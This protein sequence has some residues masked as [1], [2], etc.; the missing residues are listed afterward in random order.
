MVFSLTASY[1]GQ[2]ERILNFFHVVPIFT[3]LGQD[4]THLA[5]QENTKCDIFLWDRRKILIAF[6][7]LGALIIS[8]LPWLKYWPYG[9]LISCWKILAHFLNTLNAAEVRPK[10]NFNPYS[11]S[12]IRWNS[13]KNHLTLLSLKYPV[14]QFT[15]FM[16]SYLNS[17]QFEPYIYFR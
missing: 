5:H 4:L 2:K 16:Y 9:G 8:R 6:C 15:V 10:K 1:P 17:H 3:D 13:Q 7:Y 12:W 11:L 14:D